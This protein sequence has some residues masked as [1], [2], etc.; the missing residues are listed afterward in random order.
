[1]NIW[2]AMD[3]KIFNN[4]YS[5][6]LKKAVHVYDEQQQAIARNVA[7]SNTDNYQRVNTNFSDQLK[8][9]MDPAS[10]RVSRE[11][12]IRQAQLDNATPQPGHINSGEQVDLAR[13]MTDLS[14]NQIRHELVTRALSRY[15][16]GI[17]TAIVGRN[18]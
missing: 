2:Q 4:S 9:A 7:N 15:Y 8:S 1:M 11:Q 5:N 10:M 14:V 12:H 17:S 13:E 3:L 16:A 6:L 18:R